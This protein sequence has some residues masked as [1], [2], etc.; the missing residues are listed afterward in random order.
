MGVATELVPNLSPQKLGAAAM[1]VSALLAVG[2]LGL[3]AFAMAPAEDWHG[4][5]NRIRG[6]RRRRGMERH[7]A[8]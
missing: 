6:G 5:S 2:A 4:H 7:A 3:L 8:E 1:L